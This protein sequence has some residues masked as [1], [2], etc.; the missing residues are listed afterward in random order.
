MSKSNGTV[1]LSNGSHGDLREAKREWSSRLLEPRAATAFS[2][3]AATSPRP[4][5]NVVGVGV[6]E[7]YVDGRPSGVLA[8]KFLVR[9]KYPSGGLGA[10]DFLPPEIDGL[11]TD[12][13]E[14]GII[15]RFKTAAPPVAAAPSIVA[16]P[17]PR[18]R[19]RPAQPGSSIGF[20][21]A[22][23]RMA[24]TFGALVTDG[25]A[26]YV[27]SNNHVI[28]DE[29]RLPE[30][31]PILQPGT[32]DGGTPPLDRIAT[33]ARSVKLEASKH[34]RVDAAIARLTEP[35]TASRDVL[36]IGRPRA[37]RPAA[38]DMVVHK[39]GRTTS[40]TVGR[41][42]SVETDVTVAYDTGHFLFEDQ[43]IIVGLNGKPFSAGGDSGSLIMERGTNHSV[44]LLFA[45]SP[46]H[47]IANHL[48]DVLDALDVTLA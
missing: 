20:A 41:V 28:A 46:T 48:G 45:G 4:A 15:R 9:M 19:M 33:L 17:D 25:K 3:F 39:F 21:P 5:D 7:K 26:R 44:G 16:P 27:L 23:F 12:V 22:G 11:P 10:D 24:G 47:T 18:T 36:F 43:I 31:E 40:Y 32:L 1:A 29:D 14:V 34:N 2:A 37:V 13:E 35:G 30:D 6:G 8:V 42:T 38:R